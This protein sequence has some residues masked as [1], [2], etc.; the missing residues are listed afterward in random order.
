MK[1]I[2][3][4]LEYD[5]KELN[6]Y[7]I[8]LSAPLLLTL[9]YYYG[10]A[11]SILNYF[12]GIRESPEGEL[13]AHLTQFFSFFILTMAIPVIFIR[14]RIKQ[15]LSGFGLVLGDLKFGLKLILI[16]LPL[17]VLPFIYIASGMAEVRAEYPLAKILHQRHDLIFWYEAGYVLFYYIAWEF[18]F[19]G[20]LLFGLKSRFGAMNA[21]LIQTISSCLIHLGKPDGEILGSIV[22]GIIFGALAL[23]TRSIW[24]VFILHAAIGVLTDL[25]IIFS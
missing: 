6:T 3:A 19:R 8:L 10:S 9:Y 24:Y 2:F 18:F 7:L 22:I 20:F 14:L 17:L 21:V 25:F 12:P 1:N 16:V 4:S 5:R 13:Y 11:E 23:R 15:P